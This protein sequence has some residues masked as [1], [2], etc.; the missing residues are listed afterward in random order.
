M[1]KW[2]LTLSN[3][4]NSDAGNYSVTVSNAYGSVISSNAV[5]KVN[6]VFVYGNGQLLTERQILQCHR[7]VS[8]AYR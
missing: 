5:L 4:L 1:V 2:L 3:A 7:S 6:M 8:A